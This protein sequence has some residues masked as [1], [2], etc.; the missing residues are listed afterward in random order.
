MKGAGPQLGELK[1]VW[2][3]VQALR[4]DGIKPFGGLG[5]QIARA[6]GP[7]GCLAGPGGLPAMVF[8]GRHWSACTM[9]RA[10]GPKVL[11]KGP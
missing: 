2:C 8:H 9:G 10:G 3:A 6:G 4:L 11:K 1:A 7:G 5:L